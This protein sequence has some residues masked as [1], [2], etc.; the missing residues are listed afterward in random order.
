MRILQSH[1]DFIEYEPI[2]KEIDLAEEAEKEK[3]RVEDALVLFVS[4]EKGDTEEL[5]HRAVE[6]AHEFMQKIKV[7]KI[8]IYPFAH[9]SQ[10]LASASEALK[11]LK[12]MEKHLKNVG[13]ETYRAPFGWT[14]ALQIKIKGHPLAEQLRVYTAEEVKKEKKVEKPSV[15]DGKIEK[16]VKAKVEIKELPETDHR[17]IGKN[18]DLFSFQEEAPGQVFLHPKGMRII[19]ILT[20]FWREE[21]KKAGYLEISTP[22]LI[23]QKLW[24]RSGHWEYYKDFIF[25]TKIDDVEFGFKPMNCPGA[26]LVFKSKIRSYKDLPLRF[27]ELGRVHRK[28]LSGVLSGLFR[29][30]G[31][32]QDDAHIFVSE[33]KAAEEIYNVVKLIDKFYKI[34]GFKYHAELSTRPKNFMGSKEVWDKAETT[35]KTALKKMKIK[36]KINPGEGAFYGPKIDFHIEDSLGRSWQLATVQLDFQMAARF[37]ATYIDADGKQKTPVIIHRVIYGSLER[38]LGIL[39]EHYQGKFPVWLAPVQ[40][41]VLP[42]SDDNLKY[43]EK[44]FQQLQE[45][46][47]RVEIDKESRTLEYKIREAQLQKIPF[48]L[49]IGAKEEQSKTIAVRDRDTGKTKYGV[50]LEEFINYVNKQNKLALADRL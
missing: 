7:K 24:E 49:I 30:R 21:H 19:E 18:L 36:F 32:T 5:A 45:S 47:I 17:V 39:V 25:T 34:F 14:K 46:G 31:M 35:L 13:L 6:D 28:E 40:A 8:L 42:I 1:V 20:N 29:V 27:S 10:N 9:L 41:I 23:N 4:V 2:Q 12:E 22:Q 38:F 48:M 15:E 50:S 33:E 43:A 11:I 44:V 16:K 3:Y 26:I 37:G